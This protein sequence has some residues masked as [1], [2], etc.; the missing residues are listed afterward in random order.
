MEECPGLR[1]LKRVLMLSINRPLT[2]A[3]TSR[4]SSR[5]PRSRHAYWR[6]QFQDL[7]PAHA[8]PR[9]ARSNI[10]VTQSPLIYLGFRSVGVNSRS[11]FFRSVSGVVRGRAGQT[12]QC[13]LRLPSRSCCLNAR[14]TAPSKMSSRLPPTAKTPMG[15]CQ[16]HGSTSLLDVSRAKNQ[17]ST[18]SL[19]D[20][21]WV[22]GLKNV[23]PLSFIVRAWLILL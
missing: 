23:C 17:G 4:A 6:T 3:R 21:S 12:W 20:S 19:V 22:G 13:L 10:R 8:Q 1:Q 5:L 9:S 2:G 15:G 7:P 14:T 16:Q 11:I 18:Q